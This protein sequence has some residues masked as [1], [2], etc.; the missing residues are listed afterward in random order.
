MFLNYVVLLF[1]LVAG[2][3]WLP[4]LVSFTTKMVNREGGSMVHANL[5]LYAV[6]GALIGLMAGLGVILSG[7]GFYG[8]LIGPGLVLAMTLVEVIAIAAVVVVI[9]LLQSLCDLVAGLF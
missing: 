7:I 9:M 8:L 5:K 6:L 4:V 1:G 2:A 3:L